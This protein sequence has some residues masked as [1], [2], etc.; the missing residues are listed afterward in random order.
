[1]IL[2]LPRWDVVAEPPAD[3][4]RRLADALRLPQPLA[5]LLVQR[6]YDSADRAKRF[7]RPSLDALSDPRDLPDMDRAVAV[8]TDAVRAGAPLLIH[9]DYDVDGQ[10]ATALL[11]R[12]LRAAGAHVVPFIPNRVR[13]GYD[14]GPAGVAA[15]REA[16]AGVIVTC[17]CGTT[18]G[19]AVAAARAA[20]LKVVIT[21]HHLPGTLPEA[22]AIVNPRRGDAA[23]P[24]A[25]LCGSGVAFK[26]VQ[27]LV[28]ALGL[29][30]NLPLHLID[31]VAIAT[32]ADVVPLTAENRIL[33]RFGLRKLPETRWPGVR[34][35]VQVAGL[36][37]TEIRAGHVGYV[38]APR[39]NAAGRIG[40]AMDGLALLLSDEPAQAEALAKR[41]ETLNAQRQEM[42]Q[43]ILGEALETIE[44]D[45]D[46]ERQ[47]G[48][49]LARDGWHPGV[50]GI[51]ASRVVER[52][53]RPTILIALD[54]DTGKGSGRSISRFD[55][56]AALR[57]CAPLLERY[58]G[59]RMAAGVTVARERLEA[60]RTAFNDEARRVLTRDDLVPTQRVDAVVAL[61]D[62]DLDLE[63][64]LRHLEPCGSGNPSPV[65]G[66]AGAAV[67]EARPVGTNH[68]RLL[69]EDAGARLPAIGFDWADR[70]DPAWWRGPVDVAFRLERN[71]WQGDVSLQGRVIQ[72]RPSA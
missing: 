7:L 67:R 12:A 53:G 52:Y 23:S 14:L 37:N 71:E 62:L 4:V 45:V 20:G 46:L 6:G 27:A 25:D 55:L 38:L 47:Y 51:V 65:F 63:R 30:E 34:A 17:D 43:A 64:L 35:L 2:P 24:A 5:R 57:A 28:P 40:E 21:D 72:L 8:V 69:I 15:A 48:L 66:V 18:A 16:G 56:H 9:G 1:V 70:V 49:V 50:I 10:C 11:T 54:G 60:F 29:P 19:A 13:D 31:L 36:G 39:L 41:L 33:T 3:D 42:D 68:L 61:R 26:L 44:R 32:V 59:H 22:D 58:G